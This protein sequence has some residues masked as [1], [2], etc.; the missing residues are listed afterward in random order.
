VRPSSAVIP[1]GVEESGGENFTVTSRDPST[2]L[3]MTNHFSIKS[4]PSTINLLSHG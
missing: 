4:Q 1:S 3:G 2:S